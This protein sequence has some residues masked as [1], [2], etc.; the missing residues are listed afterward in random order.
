MPHTGRMIQET[1]DGRKKRA[2]VFTLLL[3]TRGQAEAPF[4]AEAV[5]SVLAQSDPDWRLLLLDGG[6]QPALLPPDPRFSRLSVWPGRGIA[7]ALNLAMREVITPFVAVLHDDDLLHPQAVSSL[8]KALQEHPEAD[9]FHSSR[10][11]IDDSGQF[12]SE[13]YEA[14]PVVRLEDFLD[15]C[16]VKH[17]HCWRVAKA[18]SL[19]GVD[20]GVQL[21]G[22]DDYDFPWR[23]AEAGAR[24]QAISECL[25]FQRDHRTAPRLTT[26]V[27]LSSQL[28]TLRTI[29]AKR[30]LPSAEIERQ[31][32]SRS[33]G[34]LRQALFKDEADR[35]QKLASGFDRHTGWREITRT[36]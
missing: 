1:S 11:F 16:P 26:D 30:G 27:P 21:H 12:I 20:E 13:I 4:L 7:V 23:M 32:R 8:K 3:P 33:D 14:S 31:C 24:F 34:Y 2:A 28:E 35:E 29:F 17:L 25:Y 18:L 22:G 15:T 5:Q 9:Y 19:G 10:R 36:V 6:E